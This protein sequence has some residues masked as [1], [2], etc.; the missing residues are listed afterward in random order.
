M[1]VIRRKEM[2]RNQTFVLFLSFLSLTFA[3]WELKQR[4]DC[5]AGKGGDPILPDPYSNNL[6]LQECQNVCQ[7]DTQCSGVIRKASDGQG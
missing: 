2:R 1:V 4:L 5:Y 7:Q 6:S 3:N